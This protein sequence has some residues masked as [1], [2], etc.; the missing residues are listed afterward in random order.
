MEKISVIIP[1]RNEEKYIATCLDSIINSDYPKDKMEVFLIDG[2]SVDSTVKI[3][4]NY[5]YKYNYFQLIRN[6]MKTVP[7]AMNIG[8]RNS[9]GEYIIRLDAHSEYPKDYFSK[10]IEWS[11]KL[12][13]D[14]VGA[15]WLTEVINKNKKTI[16]IKKVLS[17][18]LGV[19]NSYFRT[20]INT[21]KQVDTVPFG[22]FKREVFER[23]G[24]YDLRLERDQDIELNKRLKRNGGRI[25]LVPDIYSIYYARETFSGIAKNNFQT[26]FWNILTVYLTKRLN[27]ISL[28]HFIPLLFLS[29]LLLSLILS[30]LNPFLCYVAIISILI[31]IATIFTVSIRIVDR[32]TSVYFLVWSFIVLHFSYGFGSLIGLFRIH[33]LF[34]KKMANDSTRL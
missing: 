6:H 15:L 26:G 4:E 25:F 9:T 12:N 20:G 3:I 10:L 1:C 5:I 7:Y 2:L 28:R 21:V 31:Y 24:L 14:N 11:K 27:A 33:K 32:Q 30:I 13:A 16:S 34:E 17:N 8:I 18:K 29:F 23:I 22:C 19:G